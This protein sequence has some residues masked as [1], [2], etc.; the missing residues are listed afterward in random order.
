MYTIV[1]KITHSTSETVV[2]CSESVRNSRIEL[3]PVVLFGSAPL[4]K[5][6]Q[7]KAQ[8]FKGAISRSRKGNS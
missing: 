4:V 3:N 7:Q 5:G 2:A 8:S 6:S 1:F